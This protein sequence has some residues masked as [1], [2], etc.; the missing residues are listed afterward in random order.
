MSILYRD[1]DVVDTMRTKGKYKGWL[2]FT[3]YII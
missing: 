3:K 1:E 2:Y